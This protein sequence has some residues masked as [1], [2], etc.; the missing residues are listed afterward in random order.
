[1]A[2]GRYTCACCG[3]RTLQEKPGSY[4]ICTICFWEDD[5]VQLLDPWFPGGANGASLEQ[6]QQS[7][8]RVGVSE[9]R[10]K[11]HV[12]AVLPTDT[13]DPSWRPVQESDRKFVRTPAQLD[14]EQPLGGWQWYYWQL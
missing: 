8:A 2:R 6:A 7:F 3:Y 4:E 9:P 14:R 12:R 13:R 1:M 5:P 11:E 10:F